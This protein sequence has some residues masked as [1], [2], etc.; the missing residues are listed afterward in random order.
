MDFIPVYILF[1][2]TKET[3]LFGFRHQQERM[4]GAVRAV[5]NPAA[6][7]CNRPVHVLLPNIQFVT[8]KT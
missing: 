2:V 7:R 6:A 8:F 4:A 5:A 1:G 3:E